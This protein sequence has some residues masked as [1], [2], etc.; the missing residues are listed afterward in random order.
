VT[1]VAFTGKQYGQPEIR[2][3][4]TKQDEIVA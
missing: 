3:L 4:R 2:E 1:E